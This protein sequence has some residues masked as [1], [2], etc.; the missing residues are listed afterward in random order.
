[1]M[2]EL[3]LMMILPIVIGAG[4]R[5]KIPRWILMRQRVLR[6][7]AL[8][9]VAALIL[10]IVGSDPTAIV[11]H[12]QEIALVTVLFT[13]VLFVPGWLIS[14]AFQLPINDR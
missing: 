8:A 5:A 6:K 10:L 9:S 14:L 2:R 3:G 7:L 13:I 1:M 11:G 4:I 12:F